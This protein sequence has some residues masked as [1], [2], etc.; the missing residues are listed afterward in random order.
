MTKLE[1]AIIDCARLHLSQLKGALTLPNGPE[2]SESFSSAWWQLTGL[3]QLAEFHSGLDQP[4]RDQLRAIDREAAQAISDD[5]DSSSTTQFA[6]SISAVLADPSTSNWLKQSL[7]EALARDSVDAANDAELLFELLAHRSDEELRA[8]AHA[9]GIPE[10]TM[11]V[12]FANGRADTLD[13]SQAR[14]TII[15]GDK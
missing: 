5:R 11:A 2:R 12:R 7:N 13:V 6:N 4:A 15:T 8:S 14:H 10:T 1:Q 9:A 3:V